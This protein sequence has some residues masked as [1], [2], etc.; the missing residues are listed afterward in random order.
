M[1]YSLLLFV[2]PVALILAMSLG[3]TIG[4]GIYHLIHLTASTIVDLTCNA[5]GAIKQ[6]RGIQDVLNSIQRHRRKREREK[7]R[8]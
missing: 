1:E 5:S 7:G 6:E 8:S 4:I 2:W 3:A